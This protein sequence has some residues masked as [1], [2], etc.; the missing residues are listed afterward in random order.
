MNKLLKK[1]NEVVQE[2]FY[3]TMLKTHTGKEL[4]YGEFDKKVNSLA[5]YLNKQFSKKIIPVLSN[6]NLDYL[7]AMVACWKINKVY[8]PINFSTP[9]EKI[10]NTLSRINT[11][12]ILIRNYS[13]KLEQIKQVP[14]DFS[15]TPCEPFKQPSLSE[16]AYILSTSGTTGNPK[17]VQVSFE[18]LYWL[19]KTMNKA[20]PFHEDDIFIIS[21]PP[22]FDVSFHENL[23]FIFGKGIL[24]FIAPGTAIQQFKRLKNIL[25]NDNITHIALSPT[26]LK[27]ILS[28]TKE[29]FKNSQLKNII[30]AGE[31]LPVNLANQLLELLPK[32][33]ILNCYG[34][35]ESTI[36]ATS[37][38]IDAPVETDTVSIGTPLRG[39]KIKFYN[40]DGINS[41]NGEIL[42]GGKGVSKGYFGNPKLTTDKFVTHGNITYYKTGDLG[43]IKDGLIYYQGRKDRQVKINGIRIELEEIEQVI[44]KYLK[45]FINFNVLKVDNN[46]VLFS[47][48]KIDFEALQK[49][50]KLHLP[51]YMIPN[52]YVKVSEMKLTASNKLD[53]KYLKSEFTKKYS[54]N[55][56]NENASNKESNINNI[57]S[58]ILAE[59]SLDEMT[60]LMLLPQMDS[61]TQIEIIVALEE[62]YHVDLPEDF[63]KKTQT[64]REIRKVLDS[65]VTKDIALHSTTLTTSQKQNQYS[66]LK[67]IRD[68]NNFI[69]KQGKSFYKDSYYLQKSYIVDNF[70][71]VLEV[72]VTLP[73]NI[74]NISKVEN[75]LYKVIEKNELLR[76][77][78]N[79][80]NKLNIFEP[81]KHKIPVIS[82]SLLHNL[83]E[84]IIT[85]LKNSIY[86]NLLWEVYFDDVQNELYFFI[87]HLI[88]DQSSLGIIEKD[89]IS[90]ANGENLEN[91]SSFSDFVKFINEHSSEDTLEKV[92]IQGFKR[93]TTDNFFSKVYNPEKS[94]FKVKTPY[95]KQLDNIVFGN[96]ILS[97]LLCKSQD[98][99]IVSGSTIINLREFNKENFTS[100]FGDIHTTIPFIYKVDENE[101]MFKKS[102]SKI[103]SY[104]LTG[105]NVNN[106]IYKDYPNISKDLKKYEFYL[107]DNLKFSNNFLGAVREKDLDKTIKKLV[108]QQYSL[109]NFSKTKLYCTFFSCDN[110]LIFVPITQKLLKI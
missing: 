18:N 103:Y 46:L 110:E 105:D 3:K 6:D 76:T 97:K 74:N 12:T 16:I 94:Y 104:F 88:A 40:S 56:T 37:Y 11:K 69:L 62:Q 63:I 73:K 99:K 42:I 72:K 81:Y 23:S 59:P 10:K 106:S 83:K 15:E 66:N 65:S 34:P 68:L 8:M 52:H 20:V 98:Q 90:V 75:I 21:T 82:S 108:K 54:N 77:I 14:F 13:E 45:K 91:N 48:Q 39:A 51:T 96:Y 47:D 70:K 50:M 7:I 79:K 102:F 2:R 107:D 31:A 87:N 57:I 26:S 43:F 93:V 19:L 61:L 9:S 53:T 100:T 92:F 27:T 22:Q 78:I 89:I 29:K 30:L 60:N 35:T 49:F 67:N 17:M 58:E 38:L 44:H 55:T 101:L 24:Q 33:R 109:E 32:T 4:T 28:M 80:N 71:Q 86:N 95:K 85:D 64:I 25:V 36:Y 41:N 84:N 5:E 1:Y